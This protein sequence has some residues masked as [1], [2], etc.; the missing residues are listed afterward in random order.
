MV[1]KIG[2]FFY[3]SREFYVNGALGILELLLIIGYIDCIIDLT[4]RFTWVP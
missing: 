2:R 1:V 3:C 4:S